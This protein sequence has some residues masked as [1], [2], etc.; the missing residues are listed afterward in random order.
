VLRGCIKLEKIFP[1]KGNRIH[2]GILKMDLP[3]YVPVGAETV[4]RRFGIL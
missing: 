3:E 4:P 1:S 2:F